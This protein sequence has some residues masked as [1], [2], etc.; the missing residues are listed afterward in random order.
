MRVDVDARGRVGASSRK[1]RLL[2]LFAYAETCRLLILSL[3]GHHQGFISQ[4][5]I[6]A[7][8]EAALGRY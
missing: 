7:C 2:N 3:A 6:D 4:P 1:E 8:V 5:S